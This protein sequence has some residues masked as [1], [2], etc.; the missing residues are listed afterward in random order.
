MIFKLLLYSGYIFM[1]NEMIQ[2]YMTPIMDTTLK[3]TKLT[4]KQN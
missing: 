3:L 4:E 2:N 1:G